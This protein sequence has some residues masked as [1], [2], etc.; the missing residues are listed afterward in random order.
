M[1]R[2]HLLFILTI[3]LAVVVTTLTAMGFLLYRTSRLVP[4]QSF[5][6]AVLAKAKYIKGKTSF[7]YPAQWQLNDIPAA[8]D[9]ISVQAYESVDAIVFVASSSKIFDA[10]KV[11]GKAS[12]EKDITLDGVKGKER[13][14]ENATSGAIVFRADNLKFADRY[15]RFEMFADVSHKT[16][17]ERAWKDI[18]D[19]V[20]FVRGEE[21]GIEAKPK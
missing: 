12:E 18:L 17:A 19:S 16:K 2:S 14:W 6:N 20:R 8:Q 5:E 13:M 3:I 21:G 10:A 11:N 1:K 7:F 15:Y 9:F 4:P